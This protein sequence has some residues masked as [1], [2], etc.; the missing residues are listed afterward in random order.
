MA[1]TRGQA[2]QS[3]YLAKLLISGWDSAVRQESLPEQLLTQAYLP[4][5]KEHLVNAYGWFLVEISCPTAAPLKAPRC[6]ADL[7]DVALGKAVP[8]EIRECQ[9]LEQDGW[10]EQ[11]LADDSLAVVQRSPGNLVT[12]VTNDGPQ[13][14][15]SWVDALHKLFDRM[16]D[17]LDEY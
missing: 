10:L 15:S 2:N 3:L 16:A 9:Q 7:P 8:P 4:G 13:L 6:C 12:S 17:S 11:I 1:S 5:V 14:A